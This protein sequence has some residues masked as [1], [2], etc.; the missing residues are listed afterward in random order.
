MKKKRIAL[1]PLSLAGT[2]L[3]V[4]A[5]LPHHHHD[6]FICFSSH[7]CKSHE[8]QSQQHQHSTSDCQ[9]I[10][11]LLQTNTL[12]NLSQQSDDNEHLIPLSLDLS[13]FIPEDVF[14]NLLTSSTKEAF[15]LA[16]DEVV[17]HLFL[18][19]HNAGRAPPVC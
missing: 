9:C 5:I 8:C 16:K 4:F 18:F 19:S 17:P 13:F 14:Q 11:H 6:N 12:K 2:I 15:P 1:L 10:T 3:L 7:P